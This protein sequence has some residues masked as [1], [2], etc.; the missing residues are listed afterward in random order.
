MQ[1]D[2][3]KGWKVPCR[4]CQCEVDMSVAKVVTKFFTKG[5]S[6]EMLFCDEKCEQDYAISWVAG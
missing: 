4:H 1:L 5:R 3:F 6:T 2:L